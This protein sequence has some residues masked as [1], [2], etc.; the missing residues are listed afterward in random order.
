MNAERWRRIDEVFARVQDLEDDERTLV[1]AE[2]DPELRTEVQEML[3][4]ARAAE[5]F[6]ET[7]AQPPPPAG[8]AR[9]IP[10][11]LIA[12]RYRIAS[13]LGRGG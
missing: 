10:G 1:L 2:C 12:G 8:E 4:F 7:P 13:L 11:D 9:F 3:R 6:L 5:N